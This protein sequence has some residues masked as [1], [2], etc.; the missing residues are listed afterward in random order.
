L[1]WRRKGGKERGYR[2]KR[3]GNRG[4]GEGQAEKIWG[5]YE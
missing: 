3:G 5:G 1:T 4:E 2:R